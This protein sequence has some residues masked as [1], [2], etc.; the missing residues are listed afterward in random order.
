MVVQNDQEEMPIS[1]ELVQEHILS[2]LHLHFR[3]SNHH[4]CDAECQKST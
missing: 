1:D 3:L 2:M 4:A